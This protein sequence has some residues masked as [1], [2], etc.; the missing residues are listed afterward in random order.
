MSSLIKMSLITL[1]WYENSSKL[2][3]NIIVIATHKY[4]LS[5]EDSFIDYPIYGKDICFGI[6]T[7]NQN[8][9]LNF[10]FLPYLNSSFSIV[11]SYLIFFGAVIAE[12]L[13]SCIF[14]TCLLFVLSAKLQGL[15]EQVVLL[16]YSSHFPSTHDRAC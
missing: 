14:F 3:L 4:I 1:L 10:S 16:Y 9:L 6:L 13:F 2:F 5:T 15:R 8:T 7:G 12:V 11:T